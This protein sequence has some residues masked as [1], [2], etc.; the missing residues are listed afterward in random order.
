MAFTANTAKWRP[1]K[2]VADHNNQKQVLLAAVAA[3]TIR[4]NSHAAHISLVRLV[5]LVL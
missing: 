3:R 5:P 4:T 2:T 1:K